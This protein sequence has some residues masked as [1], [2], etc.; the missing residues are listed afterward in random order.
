MCA[1]TLHALQP[2]CNALPTFVPV[3][4]TLLAKFNAEMLDLSDLNTTYARDGFE[5]VD[6]M[7]QSLFFLNASGYIAP[8]ISRPPCHGACFAHRR[9]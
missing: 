4:D 1:A 3:Q 5:V 2:A 9:P 8:P 7:L 6:R